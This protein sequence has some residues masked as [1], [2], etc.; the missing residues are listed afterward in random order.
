MRDCERSVGELVER[1]AGQPAGGLQA[2]ARAARG[3]TGLG[4]AGRP[5]ARVPG[6]APTRSRRST[7]GSRPTAGCGPN[8]RRPGAASRRGRPLGKEG[9][10]TTARASVDGRA[11]LRFERGFRTRSSAC[12]TRSRGPSSSPSG[13]A[14]SEIELELVEGGPTSA[15]GRPRVD[16]ECRHRPPGR[17]AAA[18]R[19]H[20]HRRRRSALGARAG[21]RRL[22]ARLTQTM[23]SERRRRT[24]S[25]PGCTLPRAPRSTR[26]TAGRSPGRGPDGKSFA[27]STIK[28][29]GGGHDHRQP[30][31]LARADRPLPG[32]L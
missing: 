15:D 25:P 5:A 32:R 30:H 23:C 19:A 21:R 28:A 2:P 13:S 3:R 16:G 26:S 17:S 24:T 8:A 31:T 22:P 29:R 12:G 7:P 20:L 11:D 10:M 6:C 1:L 9:Y 27:T 18:L 14:A 4:P